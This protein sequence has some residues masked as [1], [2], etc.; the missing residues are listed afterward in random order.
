MAEP[1][2]RRRLLSDEAL[3]KAD[4]Q[5]QQGGD[6]H[7]PE[8]N[9]FSGDTPGESLM[10]IIAA[11]LADTDQIAQAARN[12][13]PLCAPKEVIA[14]QPAGEDEK[15]E[16]RQANEQ[17]KAAQKQNAVA[18]SLAAIAN[19]AQHKQKSAAPG[20]ESKR[21]RRPDAYWYGVSSHREGPIMRRPSAPPPSSP[22]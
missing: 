18:D 14:V 19:Q 9:P 1:S 15:T 17:E 16:A 13:Q 11:E 21:R 22:W 4:V 8:D 12:E 7:R 3:I 2:P 6:N 5:D 10:N 20:A